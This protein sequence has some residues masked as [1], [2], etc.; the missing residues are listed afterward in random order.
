MRVGIRKY[1]NFWQCDKGEE[2]RAKQ[3]NSKAAACRL[4][5]AA[6]ART[7]GEDHRVDQIKSFSLVRETT[8]TSGEPAA[9]GTDSDRQARSCVVQELGLGLEQGGHWNGTELF[10][11]VREASRA[12]ISILRNVL[13]LYLPLIHFKLSTES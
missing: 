2:S 11:W 9:I 12:S 6:G 1:R 5:A 10:G 4:W 3:I 8:Q 7:G 13:L